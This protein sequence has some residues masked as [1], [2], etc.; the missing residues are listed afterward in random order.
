MWVWPQLAFGGSPPSRIAI[1]GPFPQAKALLSTPSP[2]LFPPR[3]PYLFLQCSGRGRPRLLWG[4]GPQ[5]AGWWRGRALQAVL[6]ARQDSFRRRAN[7]EVQT[8]NLGHTPSTAGTFRKKFRK[9]SGRH[10]KCSQSVS[11]NFPREYGWDAPSPII[12]GI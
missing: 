10:R 5:G 12:Q 7:C 9:D 4:R 8:V 6:G 3:P 11:W 2:S 1:G